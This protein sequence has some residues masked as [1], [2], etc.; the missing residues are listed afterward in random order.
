MQLSQLDHINIQTRDLDRTC[1]FFETILG[2]HR[3]YR[4]EFP[5]PGAWFYL[6]ERA[7]V[8]LIGLTEKDPDV[9]RGSGSIN[10]VAFA[11]AGLPALLE[12][13]KKSGVEVQ[14]RDVPGMKLR[15]AFLHDPNDIM[16]EINFT[17]ADAEGER[18]EVFRV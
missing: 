8:H 17:G 7:V 9:P 11:G 12:R 18:H 6:G 4:P 10:H 15:Q 2:M 16:V 1:W 14:I 13:C 3:G 5:F